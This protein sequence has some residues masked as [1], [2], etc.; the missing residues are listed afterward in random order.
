V[1]LVEEMANEA[2]LALDI[3]RL[4]QGHISLGGLPDPTE[5]PSIEDVD[6]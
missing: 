1:P 4:D 6:L 2:I 3:E 5:E